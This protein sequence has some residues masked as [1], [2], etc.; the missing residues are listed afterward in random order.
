MTPAE[1]VELST[2]NEPMRRRSLVECFEKMLSLDEAVEADCYDSD[3]I[4]PPCVVD[5]EFVYFENSLDQIIS[6]AAVTI[7]AAGNFV[8]LDT[9]AIDRFKV[10]ELR[11]ELEKRGLSKTGLKAE[12]TEM[13]KKAMVDKISVVDIE[14]FSAG[15]NGFDE[16]C[17]WRLL[18]SDTVAI[19]PIC[20]D[21]TLLDPTS[22]K[23]QATSKSKKA[24][25][26]VETEKNRVIKMNYA[27]KFTR[28]KFVGEGL[29]PSQCLRIDEKKKRKRQQTFSSKNIK[30]TKKPIRNGILPN[31]KFTTNHRLDENSHPADW[32]RSF[33]PDIPPKG[34][35]PNV[36]SKKQWCQ[37]SNM[38]AELDCAGDINQEG[39]E[40]KFENFTPREI[41][42]N[43]SLYIFQGLNPS[44]QLVMKTKPQS[45][46]PVQGND[47]IANKLGKNFERRHRQFR[48]YFA[49]QH[50]YKP[51]PPISSHPN[52]KVDP[53]LRQL[54][55]ICIQAAVLPEKLSVDEQTIM[56]HG[57]SKLKSRIKYKKTGDGFQC[58]S[59]CSNGYTVSFYFRHQPAPTKYVEKGF[60]PLH[61]RVLFMFD[62][63]KSKNH[64]VF[65]DNLYMSASFARYSINSINKIKIH[66]VTRT[67]N[68]GIP[69]C[70]LQTELQNDKM[71]DEQRNTVKVAVL[72]NDTTIKDLVAISFYDS[73]PVY[74]LST[75]IPEVKW[76]AV[77]KHIFSKTLQRKISLPF[78]R[79]NFF[80]K[81]NFDMKSVN[82][83]D[84]LR[85]NYKVGKGIKQ[86][87][88]WWSIFLW[89]LDVAIV[90]SY[91]LYKS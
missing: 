45:V 57:S 67:D 75:V 84:H 89:G 37:F 1:N 61:S 52:W 79:P 86:Q 6:A 65:M 91:L 76:T 24:K 22:S 39:L 33:L 4:E 44:P 15:P 28:D 17:R 16:G 83:A 26:S 40:Y 35:S 60:S 41:E 58:D 32:L 25:S 90:N 68:R 21:P 80:N 34:S 46:E 23:Y 81:Y 43:L 27:K 87:T 5:E 63:L 38:K 18:E 2:P 72:E 74:F 64:S 36:F 7:P 29:Q 20:E 48:R 55:N 50:P 14:K 85:T 11:Q 42:Q 8:F 10:D 13:L 31:I 59:I 69:K 49:C 9:N 73:K 56:F 71:A 51:V 82:R 53:L 47:F 30:Y 19:E 3:G 70:V 54:S 77:S 66:G 62:Q 78:L 12:L 88:W